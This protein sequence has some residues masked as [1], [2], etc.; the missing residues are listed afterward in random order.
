MK[1]KIRRVEI[2]VYECKK[3]RETTELHNTWR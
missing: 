1:E 3:R 2:V